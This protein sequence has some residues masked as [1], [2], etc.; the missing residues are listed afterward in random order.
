MTPAH[1]KTTMAALAVAGT[2]AHRQAKQGTAISVGPVPAPA[3]GA[4][5]QGAA[6]RALGTS[7]SWDEVVAEVN[8]A[9][10]GATQVHPAANVASRLGVEP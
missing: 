2:P 6:P 3:A 5:A 9:V 7:F 1:L 4:T 10:L 8:K